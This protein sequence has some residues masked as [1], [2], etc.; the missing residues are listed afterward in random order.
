M[1]FILGA[2]STELFDPSFRQQ[3]LL[4]IVGCMGL[5][6]SSTDVNTRTS[7]QGVAGHRCSVVYSMESLDTASDNDSASAS[8][9]IHTNNN[10]NSDT[11]NNITT[12]QVASAPYCVIKL[13][14]MEVHRTKPLTG[15]HYG[16]PICTIRTG[17]LCV[18]E[19]P[20]EKAVDETILGSPRFAFL[21]KSKT[22]PALATG[23]TVEI[24][25][26]S[27][28][29]GQ[30]H[31]TVDQVREICQQQPTERLEVDVVPV[32]GSLLLFKEYQAVLALR[33]RFASVDDLI[34][35]GKHPPPDSQKRVDN[36]KATT[37]SNNN[38]N[39]K[40]T[41]DDAIHLSRKWS[42][43]AADMEF[44]EVRFKSFFQQYKK[45]D[46]VTKLY[47]V[48]PGPDPTRPTEATE[49]MSAEQIQEE[50]LQPSYHFV[51][52][53][54]GNGVGKVF[55]EILGC[56]DLPDMD[57]SVN[58]DD[59]TDPF[60][61][62]F[63]EDSIVRSDMLWDH[64]NP[65]WMPWT[66]RAF[67]FHMRHPTSLLLI[68]VFDYDETPLEHHN[69]VGRIVIDVSHFYANTTYLLS[70]NLQHDPRVP[71][72][73]AAQRGRIH[74]RLRVEWENE[75]KVQRLMYSAL[76]KCI[77]NCKTDKTFQV[78]RYLKRGSLDMEQPSMD[79][80]KVFMAE[81]GSYWTRYCYF[82]DVALEI[83]LWRGRLK[84]NDKTSIWFSHHSIALSAAVLMC[85]EYPHRVGPICLYGIAWMLL[86][87]NFHNS[88][89]P[90]PWKRTKKWVYTNLLFFTKDTL[91]TPDQQQIPP[92]QGYK[93]GQNRD[94]L[95]EWRGKLMRALISET[96]TFH[97]KVYQIY[98]TTS[99]T[100]KFFSTDQK[101]WSL[102]GDKL[103]YPHLMLKLICKFTRVY[104]SFINW[105][106]Y[107]ATNG[108]VLKGIALGTIGLLLPVN[109]IL[110]W[111][112]RI[113]AWTWL[114]PWMK[115][116]DIYL[117]HDWYKTSDKLADLI[118]DGVEVPPP[119][120]PNYD[121][122][123]QSGWLADLS[124]EGRLVAEHAA[125]LKD[126]RD[127]RYGHYCEFITNMNESR[128]PSIPLPQSV[129]TP[130]HKQQATPNSPRPKSPKAQQT[131]FFVPCQKLTGSMIMEHV[132]DFT[133]VSIDGDVNDL[134]P[135]PPSTP[136]RRGNT[137]QRRLSPPSTPTHGLIR[138]SNGSLRSPTR[139][140]RRHVR[141]LST[142][143]HSRPQR[144]CN[145]CN[146]LGRSLVCSLCRRLDISR[147]DL[148][149]DTT[150]VKQSQW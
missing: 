96:L 83:F 93:E 113:L 104:L 118:E 85:L 18:L 57:V 19:I 3:I 34:F 20:N 74:V 91:L 114:G 10:G 43:E 52:A 117:V 115:L 81:I 135:S 33:M 128:Y 47:R 139:P 40:Y 63:F 16:N 80:V 95:D 64:I 46:G 146:N 138:S 87:I 107:T 129:A 53:G 92:N 35:M 102:L 15:D 50:S 82:L 90:Y 38:N 37:A 70:Y 12:V 86:S 144:C 108:A 14:Q 60:V 4:E 23:I 2:G 59:R 105:D 136:P 61:A 24:G 29:L 22:L 116:V 7:T 8:S 148:L 1:D 6:N 88:R 72:D 77:I 110:L 13:A 42:K 45:M 109:A 140:T 5:S 56:N 67:C 75:L 28:K 131:Q 147:T 76:P 89:H 127:H 73:E 125:K 124:Y 48:M 54:T 123:L 99:V 36:N 49:W 9:S 130:Y 112:G 119:D 121:S 98:S 58:S 97:N 30:V 149:P 31:L 132:K 78:L 68:G 26:G 69:A 21:E 94:K 100:S 39:N 32:R 111:V 62:M 41:P 103:A 145:N 65:R 122:I 142:S 134:P 126:M 55:V 44:K 51:H 71:P 66:M 120:L 84:L 133:L 106:G 79:S 11:T 143:L 150:S 25:E 141:A 27:H 17:S 137:K 101:N